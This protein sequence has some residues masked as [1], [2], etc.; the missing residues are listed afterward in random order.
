MNPLHAAIAV[1]LLWTGFL[2]AFGAVPQTLNW[3]APDH[4]VLPLGA[5]HPLRAEASS[6]LPVQFRVLSG[7]AS[8]VGDQLLVTNVAEVSVIAEQL[9]DETYRAV[10]SVRTFNDFQVELTSEPVFRFGGGVQELVSA[11]DK[12]LGQDGLSAFLIRRLPSKGPVEDFSR[13]KVQGTIL[14]M[15]ASDSH[16]FT[17]SSVGRLLALDHREPG[18]LSTVGGLSLSGEL[19][20]MVYKDG[21]LFAAGRAGL[22]IVDVKDPTQMRLLAKYL[23]E[24]EPPWGS[25][26]S[27][28][29]ASGTQLYLR[30][31]AG[32][33][34]LDVSDP[35]RP[36]LAGGFSQ[37]GL[38]RVVAVKDSIAGIVNRGRLTFLDLQDPWHVK[39]AGVYDFGAGSGVIADVQQA[40]DL[41]FLTDSSGTIEV[42][43][44]RSPASPRLLG[45]SVEPVRAGPFAKAPL[46]VSPDGSRVL[47]LG[48]N[49][50][51]E[52]SRVSRW[53]PQ[54]IT[55]LQ[56]SKDILALDHP[57]QLD[58]RASSGLSLEWKI[59]SGPAIIGE[60]GLR[61]TG[62]GAVVVLARQAG[63]A[64][65][66]PTELSRTFNATQFR[67]EKIG[68]L[69]LGGDV[70]DL[71]AA[72]QL[73]FVAIGQG[74]VKVID[75]RRPEAP[76][77]IGSFSVTKEARRLVLS[78][79]RLVVVG[80]NEFAVI[81]IHDPTRP[82]VLDHIADTGLQGFDASVWGA[83][84]LVSQFGPGYG[85]IYR[86]DLDHLGTPWN[87]FH[88]YIADGSQSV[89]LWSSLALVSRWPGYDLWD[90]SDSLG[91]KRLAQLRIPQPFIMSDAWIGDSMAWIV[92]SNQNADGKG[93]LGR[94]EA[95]RLD[96]PQRPQALGSGETFE[97]WPS[98]VT[99]KG[100]WAFVG[101]RMGGH[102]V[103]DIRDPARAR[104]AGQLAGTIRLIPEDGFFVAATGS[105]S[106]ETYVWREGYEQRL[107]WRLE[108]RSVLVPGIGHALDIRSS[109]G[110]PITSEV[111]SGPA[112]IRDGV[113]TITNEA[114]LQS[115]IVRATQSGGN[116]YYPV[117]SVHV[118]NPLAVDFE[119]LSELK[120]P[121]WAS[122]VSVSEGFACVAGWVGPVSWVDVR[123]PG[124]PRLVTS[125]VTGV[126]A[127]DVVMA[128][129]FAFAADF[130]GKL[131]VL[132]LRNPAAPVVGASVEYGVEARRVTVSGN[133]AYVALREGVGV[134]DISDPMQPRRAGMLERPG[135]DAARGLLEHDGFLYITE[136]SGGVTVADVRD[137]SHPKLASSL[138]GFGSGGCVAE[139]N[140]LWLEGL[141]GGLYGADISDPFHPRWEVAS[142][143]PLPDNFQGSKSITLRDGM[144]YCSG[145]RGLE[146]ID[147]HDPNY[148]LAS[149]SHALFPAFLNGIEVVGDFAYVAAGDRGLMIF[150]IRRGIR[151]AVGDLGIPS[152]G[153]S[154]ERIPLPGRNHD[155]VPMQYEVV[156][157]PAHIEGGELRLDGLESVVLKAF[158]AP[159]DRYLPAEAIVS[160]SVAPLVLDAVTGNPGKPASLNWRLATDVLESAASP[161]GPWIALPEARPPFEPAVGNEPR[162][163]RVMRR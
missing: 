160:I 119:F 130:G 151:S 108:D 53:I 97:G 131:A 17:Y 58:A 42:V 46:V 137:P 121:G 128:G 47:A 120:V 23:N 40:E 74:E 45:R 62:K 56:P 77:L 110:M 132:D 155:G 83:R 152:R 105:Q 89:R 154:G 126:G 146:A 79:Q 92:S 80:G 139:G 141:F 88:P 81:D 33:Q 12:I 35:T 112:E 7:P 159:S 82:L 158:L 38:S 72:N 109:S 143:I 157:G 129:G 67:A 99:V 101:D 41:L 25:G 13:F 150:R 36:R 135:Y 148:V 68:S 118:F 9:G 19:N 24:F 18:W 111:L 115:V 98:S 44:V 32:L 114:L 15:T 60:D 86:F 123:N 48:P 142:Q 103:F 3:T 106:L 10:T 96:D 22:F 75:L 93:S 59:V 57:H 113:L 70:M 2:P 20:S 100:A 8:I 163:F 6:G 76:T 85:G 94:L 102:Q 162:F 125:L 134:V 66:A 90:V 73:A 1:V 133:Y 26:F 16:V 49:G 124:Q 117:E 104:R 136:S 84:L 149:G 50:S 107:D 64:E 14:A 156:S 65:V 87:P 140:Q 95:Y 51:M 34:I 29:V 122:A 27:Q 127:P 28:V 61:L 91:A 55:W 54:E 5:L 30:V 71:C 161:A 63:T 31:S 153:E 147:I 69:A 37:F 78:D 43:S 138:E 11:G 145:V 21:L 144:I 52:P 39:E 4:P 116:G